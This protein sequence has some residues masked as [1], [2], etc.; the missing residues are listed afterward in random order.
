MY[1]VSLHLVFI[2]YHLF[3]IITVCS[4]YVEVNLKEAKLLP[5]PSEDCAL[6]VYVVSVSYT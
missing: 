3:N 4:F 6:I 2:L 1:P 5:T